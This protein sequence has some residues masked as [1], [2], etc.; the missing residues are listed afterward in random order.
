MYV[1]NDV[2]LSLYIPKFNFFLE[3]WNVWA[4]SVASLKVEFL[5]CQQPTH[6][7]LL[8]RI[9]AIREKYSTCTSW[10]AINAGLGFLEATEGVLSRCIV[11]DNNGSSNWVVIVKP[12]QLWVSVTYM[13]QTTRTGFLV[14]TSDLG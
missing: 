3:I 14:H 10:S 5:D 1:S 8:I 9:G 7:N 12:S 4:H 11:T 2:L 6:L 13:Y